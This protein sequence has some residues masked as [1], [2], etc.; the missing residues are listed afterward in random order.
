MAR[1]NESSSVMSEDRL[2]A[3]LGKQ[4]SCLLSSS[5]PKDSRLEAQTP[6]QPRWLFSFF[7]RVAHDRA[8]FA[9][10]IT[11]LLAIT[12]TACRE[13]KQTASAAVPLLKSERPEV[14][15]SLI[16]NELAK[17]NKRIVIPQGRHR[18]QA[19]SGSHLVFSD[20][21]DVEII[22]EDVE[23]L[24]TTTVRAVLFEDCKNVTLRGLSVDYDPLPFT[25][26]R[27]TAMAPDKKWIEFEL[28]QGYPE[29]ELNDPIQIYNPASGTL[30]R[31]DARWNASIEALGNR[32][33][34]I[35]K[36]QGYRY[37]PAEDTEQIG[38]IV[39]TKNFE[40]EKGSPH[41]IELRNCKGVRLEDVTLFASPSFGFLE[42]HCDGN[43]YLRCKVNR[44]T[45]EDDPVKRAL[46]RMRSLNADAFH[47]K[48]AKTGPAIV[49]C[50]ARFM[51]DDAVNING[52][53]H[54]VLG[55][56]GREMR[57][58]I[59]DRTSLI[60]V[61][62]PVEFLPY[63]GARP[64]DAKVV[65]RSLETQPMTTEEK[66]FIRK[67]RM[68]DDM[69]SGLLGE[70]VAIYKLTLD[71]EVSLAP[72]SA[73]C[74][75]LRLGRGFAVKDCEFG[76]NRSRGILIKASKGEVSG[77]RITNSRMAAVLISPEFWWME[78]GLSSDVT[79]KD[80]LIEGCLESPIQIRAL[81]GNRQILPAGALRNISIVN[82]RIE[83]GAL[84]LI[85]VTST[86]GLTIKDNLLPEAVGRPGENILL[87]NC[88]KTH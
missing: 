4:A 25:Q 72:G 33:H 88:E 75:P 70:K 57:I 84:P 10:A 13:K 26:G 61:G 2:P 64:P 39:V 42:R 1:R 59:I 7:Q 54:Y 40:G 47:S 45:P 49:S 68:D 80:N 41:A 34:R 71:R 6:K 85:H 11:A 23:L 73:V 65:K 62:D 69:R 19:D 77:N 76:D 82:N 31:D 51:G 67:L 48:D 36:A 58:A 56:K 44:R 83:D 55:S 14:L 37:N 5:F 81:G 43:T 12:L 3:C 30:R 28:A 9:P 21:S 18:V 60:K 32:R 87:E 27:I 46:P 63:A 29:N 78:A 35:S 20:L 53:Y 52:R 66:A 15:R 17:G 38:D 86:S 79:I 50:T 16:A 24:C 8:Y 74:C 22:A